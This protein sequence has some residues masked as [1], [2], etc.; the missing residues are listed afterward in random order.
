MKDNSQEI[1]K[2]EKTIK[3]LK[4]KYFISK[5]VFL[6]VS[7]FLIL[8]SA[9]NGLLS[10]YAIVKNNQIIPLWIFVSIAFINAIIAFLLAISAL[11]NF[12]K[13]KDANKE[14]IMFLIQKEKELKENPKLVDR[15]KLINDLATI[16]LDE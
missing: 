15:D 1:L 14:K 5:S 4:K 2:A 12:D 7:I 10:A 6:A 8:A 13:K 11:C 9:F 16:D 3:E